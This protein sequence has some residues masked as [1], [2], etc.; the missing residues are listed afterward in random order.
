[1]QNNCKAYTNKIQAKIKNFLNPAIQNLITIT[2][3]DLKNFT[4]FQIE[5]LPE[6][7]MYRYAQ[8]NE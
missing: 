3:K 1:M 8:Q 4:K 6:I 2:E 7:R 5:N